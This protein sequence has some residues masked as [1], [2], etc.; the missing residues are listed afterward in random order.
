MSQHLFL[1]EG[2]YFAFCR[3]DEAKDGTWAAFVTFERRS[4]HAEDKSQIEAM[5]HKVGNGYPAAKEAMGAAVDF[6]SQRAAEG[7]TG[8]E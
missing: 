8:L 4:D 2:P 5:S 1:E 6:A 7:R 3:A